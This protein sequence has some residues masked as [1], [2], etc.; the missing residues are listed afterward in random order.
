MRYEV[1]YIQ[2][3]VK[4]KQI[5]VA[6]DLVKAHESFI[7]SIEGTLAENGIT[8]ISV[9]QCAEVGKPN[10]LMVTGWFYMDTY[11][12][13]N[14]VAVRQFRAKCESVGINADNIQNAI[15]RNSDGE[16]ITTMESYM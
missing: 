6:D 5:V 14:E 9:G 12:T 1:E 8:Y 16:D 10:E 4:R 3:G 2:G 15:I 13:T 11:C 7:A